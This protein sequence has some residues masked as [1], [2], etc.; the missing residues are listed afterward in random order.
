MPVAA[1]VLGLSFEL[2]STQVEARPKREARSPRTLKLI[3][4]RSKGLM[5]KKSVDG[6][7]TTA[8][9]RGMS[10]EKN[11]HYELKLKEERERLLK[12]LKGKETP[13]D[14]GDDVDDAEGI[15][16]EEAEELGT[17]LSIGQALRDRINEIDRALQKIGEGSYGKCIKCGGVISERVL[18]VAPESEL[19][20]NCKKQ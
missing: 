7:K 2:E 5:I 8:T 4:Q 14:F 3:A 20:E 9:L 13:A 10:M 16:A 17:N 6:V 1:S 15:E 12:E 19:C 18:D 11:H